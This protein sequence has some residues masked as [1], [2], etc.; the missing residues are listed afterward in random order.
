[1]R[2]IINADDLGM[3]ED[4]NFAIFGLMAR[5]QVTSATI[6]A[7]A[8]AAGS[9]LRQL[10][11]HPTCSFGVHLNMTQFRPL[12]AE[13]ALAPFLAADGEFHHA[14][15]RG[16]LSPAAVEGIAREWQAQV[17][18][19]RAQ[20]A[21]PS[22]VDSHHHVHSHPYLFPA[23][24]R[25]LK[26]TGVPRV[27]ISKNVNGPRFAGDRESTLGDSVRSIANWAVNSGLRRLAK[28]ADGFTSL[29]D[30]HALYVSGAFDAPLW[31]RR[32]HWTLELM[33]HPGHPS[34]AEE[35]ALLTS[36]WLDEIPHQRVSYN[37]L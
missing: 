28:T 23:I 30:F 2:L 13:T 37:V 6:L 15:L 19:V 29:A 27:R 32:N 7:N 33:V 17:A 20:G 5:G 26:R 36:G 18:H 35:T 10:H 22:H 31:R 9:A 12:T 14:S 25:F 21:T 4:V 3:N 16:A 11:S 8:P 1:M 24:G 34:Y